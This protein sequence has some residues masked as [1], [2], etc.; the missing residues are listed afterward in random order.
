ME[1]LDLSERGT[2]HQKAKGADD[3]MTTAQG[4]AVADYQNWLK[5]D[6]RGPGLLDDQIARERCA[7]KGLGCR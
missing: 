6:A 2:N 7:G 4:V 3:T 5:A 1:D